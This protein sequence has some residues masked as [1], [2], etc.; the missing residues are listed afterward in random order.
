MTWARTLRHDRVDPFLA[1][2]AGH[3]EP[4]VSRP[5]VTHGRGGIYSH[6]S[7]VTGAGLVL[8]AVDGHHQRDHA[9]D[10]RALGRLVDPPAAPGVSGD[11]IGGVPGDFRGPQGG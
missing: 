8:H 7:T 3:L 5:H 11:R 9:V 1:V 4:D 2:C 6:P 10:V